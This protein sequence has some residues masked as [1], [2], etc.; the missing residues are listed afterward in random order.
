MTLAQ[1]Y[2]GQFRGDIRLRGHDF[3]KTDRVSLTRV[4][5]D[6]IQAVVQDGGEFQSLLQRQGGELK[7][8][9]SCWPPTRPNPA[10][11]HLWATILKVDASGLVAGAVKSGAIP[12]FSV[13]PIHSRPVEDYW[14][15]ETTRDVF[16]PMPASARAAADPVAYQPLKPW[17][18]KLQS[19]SERLHSSLNAGD[20][21]AREREIFYEIDEAAS[22]E[23][24]QLVLQVVQR[25]RRSNGQWGKLKP[26][27]LRADRLEEIED[28]QDRR[29]VSQLVGVTPDRVQW[30]ALPAESGAIQ[31]FYLAPDLALQVVPSLCETSR[32]Q[33]VDRHGERRS[34][35]EWDHQTPWELGVD[36]VP[37]D[38]DSQWQV[39][40][41]LHRDGEVRPLAEARLLIPGGLVFF[42]N[43]VAPFRDF[44]TFGWTEVLRG[45][46]SLTVPREDGEA[47][48]D[49]LLDMPQL[50]R[51]TLPAELRLSEIAVE[52]RPHLTLF[53]PRGVRW[54]H[55]RLTGEVE[56]EYEGARVRGTSPQGAIVQREQGRCLTRDRGREEVF[57]RALEGFGARRLQHSFPGRND[58]EI[59][60]KALASV[61]RGLIKEGW[62]IHA[63]GRQVHQP[64][65][66]SF[67]IKTGIDWFELSASVAFDG[68]HVSFPELLS[69][70]ARGDCTVRL[71]DGSLG[72]IPEEWMKQ[73]GL[74]A[75]LGI[76]DGETVRFSKSQVGL[77]DALLAAERAVSFDET[78]DQLRTRVQQFSGIEPGDPPQ[79]FDGELRPYQSAGV[80]WL[81]FLD[82]FGFG[83]CL[84]D[85][86]GLGKTIQLLAFLEDRRQRGIAKGP[87]LVVVPR[88]LIF[89]WHQEATRF[90]PGL[91]V[92]EYTGLQRGQ[93]RR[94]LARA[95]LVL[96]TYGTI[97]RDILQL[98]EVEFD[99]VVLDEAQAIKNPASQVAK[100]TRLIPGRHRIALSGTPIENHLRD[101]WSIFEFLNPG[102]L[103]RASVFKLHTTDS[104]D[105]ESRK[106]LSH[107]LRPF[108]LR[109]T[110]RE[111]AK[112][113]PEKLEQTIYCH[114]PKQQLQLYQELR[115]HYRETLLGRV[116]SQGLGKSKI[117][118][119]EALLRLRQAACHPALLDEKH[120]AE[121]TAKLEAL[122]LHLADLL[123]EGHKALVFSQF[124]SFLAIVQNFL[125]ERGMTYEYLDGQTRNRRERI[126]RFQNDPSCGIF[127][128]S[129]KAG[130]LGLN[131]TSADYVFLL[132]P[133]W[134]PAV[135]MQAIDRAHRIGQTR[136]VF[137][138]RLI[139]KDTV[140]EKIAELQT[141]KKELADAILQADNNLL[142]DLTAD[143]LELLLS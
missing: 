134:N 68:R 101:L 24:R 98:K 84:A 66:L 93:L 115:D 124:T 71:N 13:E 82:E 50:P 73:F 57:W 95:D 55:E 83:G 100:A 143:D 59:P 38:N 22:R 114:M 105:E 11:K 118:V 6:Q 7:F 111:V 112:E 60:A 81:R 108:I 120:A 129:L 33:V 31:R 29:I 141:R 117:H 41:R 139:C 88:S 5:P 20:S 132:D 52:P 17:Q 69:A 94:K 87:T 80:S 48:V 51:L 36:V 116:R 45:D 28:E 128:I 53:T 75:S 49:R 123:A 126:E 35:L 104:N 133:W 78:F 142:S 91:K 43:S 30:Q 25:Q 19:L 89:N 14:D 12:P 39:V 10:C 15:A 127:L 97:R 62:Q 77:L 121:P 106:L 113:L 40:G 32:L 21:A 58:V 74:L 63:D 131:L 3:F 23:R 102:M 76:S 47:L 109:R 136:T 130:G 107:A 96:T 16:I 79:G 140:E 110:K 72:V 138:Y 99:Y 103:G 65:P 86:M 67:E 70:L 85:D 122:G 26:L 56:F 125:E 34:P 37:D 137:A 42:E 44:G 46:R 9:C 27:K 61:V 90:T 4:D 2:E 1:V 135:E 64:G 18:Q 8:A 92:L 119:L 54:Q